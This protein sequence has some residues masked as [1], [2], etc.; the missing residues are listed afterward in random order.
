MLKRLL[1]GLAALAVLITVAG[2][3][4]THEW[5][6]ADISDR[7]PPLDFTLTDENGRTVDESDYAGKPTLLFFGYTHCPDVCP[8]TLAR[9]ASVIRQLDADDRGQVQVLF[10]S[11]DPARDTP[12][13]LEAYTD[14]FNPR[15]VGLTGGKEQID[16]VTNRYRVHY[17]YGDKDA[18]GDYAVTHS[19]A[20]MAFRRDG[21]PAFLTRDTDSDAAL[22]DDLEALLK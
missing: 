15:F 8:V 5:R 4:E 9:L 17:S 16:A 21:E 22:I 20:V 6:T 1:F 19:S 12:E 2:C 14:A 11:V 13:V 10:V 18:D 3:E 7:L